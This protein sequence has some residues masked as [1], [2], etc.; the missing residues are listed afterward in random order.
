MTDKQ[1]EPVIGVLINSDGATLVHWHEGNV[2]VERLESDIP[3]HH[4][5]VG[6]VR[7]GSGQHGGSGDHSAGEG[8]R[9]EARRAFIKQVVAALPEHDLLIL[10][11]SQMPGALASAV[12]AADQHSIRERDRRVE[13]RTVDRLT[14]HQ[15]VAATA[16]FAG[17]PSRRK[18]P[19]GED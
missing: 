8:P 10:G 18:L 16:E 1:H 2:R 4:R 3:A 5:S 9:L 11:D 19:R 15:L 12:T 17:A 13:V 14:E 7:M 6:H